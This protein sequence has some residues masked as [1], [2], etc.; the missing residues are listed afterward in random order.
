[1]TAEHPQAKAFREAA[2]AMKNERYWKHENTDDERAFLQAFSE[3]LTEV[4][5]Q[6]NRYK[7]LDQTGLE[8][9]RK[10]A[11]MSMP[12]FAETSAEVILLGALQNRLE[13]LDGKDQ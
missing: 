10:A 5:F 13:E 8:A 12:S 2:E 3:V 1:M 9:Y 6:L 11:P 7:I 4:A